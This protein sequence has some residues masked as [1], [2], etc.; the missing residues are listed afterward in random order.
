MTDPQ[1]IVNLGTGGSDLNGQ[2]G[3]TS[4][5][6]SNDAKFLDWPG[7]NTGNYV[8]QPGVSGNNLE[9]PDEAALDITDEIDVRVYVALDDWVSGSRQ[10]IFSKWT[11]GGNQRSWLINVESTGIL[12]FQY[13][14]DGSAGGASYNSTQA[15]TVSDGEALWLRA[16][17]IKDNGAGNS[18]VNFYTSTDGSTWS[19]LGASVTSAVTDSI[20]SSTSPVHFSSFNFSA[21]KVYRGQVLDGIGGTTVLD[22]DTSKLTSGSDTSFTALTGQTVT[23]NRSASGRKS[24]AVVSPVWLFGTDDYMEVADNALLNFTESEDFTVV[25][26]VRAWGTAS[27]LQATASKKT[28]S[29]TTPG[30]FLSINT[31]NATTSRVADGSTQPTVTNGSYIS[32]NVSVIGFLRDGTAQ[33]MQN[34]TG[35]TF[36]SSSSVVMSATLS[37]N[38]PFRVGRFASSTNYFEGEVL[39]V[40]VFR[41]LL[42]A[43]EIASINTYY[44]NK[45]A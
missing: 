21:M 36:A 40:L 16:T 38:S 42:T 13:T 8:Y 39:G 26:V 35:S 19:A 30:Y 1:V 23:I 25:T 4:S 45:A 6:D 17:W 14:N 27:A 31:S 11:S 18:E 3:S 10:T 5:A 29:N 41:R 7:D 12:V 32:G 34:F 33:T 37:N 44:Q 43:A 22:L 24:V 9:V 20:Y 28:G 15:P 2:N